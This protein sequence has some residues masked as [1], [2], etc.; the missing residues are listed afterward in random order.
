MSAFCVVS[1][2][3]GRE[4]TERLHET[5]SKVFFLPP[6]PSI[7]TPVG[8]H[9]DMLLSELDGL[10]FL[11]RSYYMT[12][13]ELI[14]S[15]A[16]MGGLT[17]C[18]IEV[19]R[20]AIYPYDVSFNV[21]VWRD[22]V[23]CRTSSTCPELLSA[24]NERGYRIVSV[25]QGYAGCSCL[26]TDEAVLTFDRGIEET[27]T[28]HGIPCVLA[29]GGGVAL[30][31]Y[32]CGFLGGAGGFFDGDIYI[33]GNADTLP[34]AHVLHRYGRVISLSTS[35]VTDRGGIKIFKKR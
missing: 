20:R 10:L 12:N 25:K 1:S 8:T 35:A 26:V 4:V 33:F 32:D 34:C 28:R 5:F 9:P 29:D 21:A 31:G 27:L 22:N 6:D 18:P 13:T 23:I 16:D 15:I 17:V 11:P 24:A 19:E 30:P 14:E 2:E 7:A 3:V